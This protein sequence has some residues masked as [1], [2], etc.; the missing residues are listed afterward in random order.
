MVGLRRDR[1]ERQMNQ[2]ELSIPYNLRAY[3]QEVMAN[4]KAKGAT[5]QHGSVLFCIIRI[6]NNR[7][8]QLPLALLTPMK[9]CQGTLHPDPPRQSPGELKR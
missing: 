6:K 3:R 4:M 2:P 7:E 9:Y 5:V 8:L 1:L